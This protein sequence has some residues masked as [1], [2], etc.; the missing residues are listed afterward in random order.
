MVGA[1]LLLMIIG[2][3]LLSRAVSRSGVAPRWAA[4]L[5]ALAVPAFAL[6][7]LTLEVLQPVA[8]LLVAVGAGMLAKGASS[9]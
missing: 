3:A 6:T 7:G 8:G 9:A 4:L 1:G 2:A 5:F